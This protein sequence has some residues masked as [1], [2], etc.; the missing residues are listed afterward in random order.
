M[1]TIGMWYFCSCASN[2][3]V[4]LAGEE[5][6]KQIGQRVLDALIRRC[7]EGIDL[8]R[9]ATDDD[10]LEMIELVQKEMSK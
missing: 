8:V 2:D 7:S 10:V 1:S 4:R 6:Y 9:F 5:T 3:I